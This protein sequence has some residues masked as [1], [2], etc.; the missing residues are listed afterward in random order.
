[1]NRRWMEALRALVAR[2]TD[3]LRRAR[4]TAILDRIDTGELSGD[5]AVAAVVESKVIRAGDVRFLCKMLE[6]ELSRMAGRKFLN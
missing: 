2:E 3:P 5:R 4:S 1:M 6:P